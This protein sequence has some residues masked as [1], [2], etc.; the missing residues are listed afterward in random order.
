MSP[1]SRMTCLWRRSTQHNYVVTHAV[2]WLPGA[3]NA[4]RVVRESDP[5]GARRISGA[6][7]LLAGDPCPEGSSV[8]GSTAFRRLRLE[9]YRVL[10]EVA[11]GTVSVMHVGSVL[12]D[13]WEEESPQVG[14]AVQVED[15]AA[16]P[17]GVR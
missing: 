9:R 6:V 2:V 10:Y 12:P 17:F 16:G 8:L 13:L 11:P 1:V 15:R 7:A 14:G 3:M 5:E 4:Y